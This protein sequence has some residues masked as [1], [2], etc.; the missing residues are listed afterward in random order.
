M[1]LFR[2]GHGDLRRFKGRTERELGNSQL[3]MQRS[4]NKGTAVYKDRLPSP[5]SSHLLS[6]L[7]CAYALFVIHCAFVLRERK[8]GELGV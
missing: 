7:S 5:S 1:D 8:N 4:E 2:L 3:G 6:L